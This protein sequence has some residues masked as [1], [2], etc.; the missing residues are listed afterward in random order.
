MPR[1]SGRPTGR[2]SPGAVPSPAVRLV[3]LTGFNVESD[4][5][6]AG[7][8]SIVRMQVQPLMA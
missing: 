4:E 7:L 1:Q 5:A 3:F 6:C 2:G 8:E